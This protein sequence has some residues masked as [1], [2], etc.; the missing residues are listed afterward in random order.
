MSVPRPVTQTYNI[1]RSWA[2]QISFN[3]STGWGGLSSSNLQIEFA[4][5]VS[6]IRIGG[7]AIYSPTLPNSSE[8]AN[9]F[10][11]YKIKRVTTRLDWSINSYNPTANDVAAVVP[12]IF[13]AVDHDDSAD[14]GVTDLLQYPGVITHSFLTNGYKP[15]IIKHT[16]R[17]LRDVAG[18]G[19]TT[20][21]SPM[22][23]NPYLR[24]SGMTTP[25]YGLKI[26]GQSM[27][28]SVNTTV[29]YLLIT[30]YFDLELINP[31]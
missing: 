26:A 31:K 22:S 4:A 27:G 28:A 25:H 7:V 2:Q 29:G 1:R 20:D 17:P 19:I 13:A 11:Q 9:L 30:S 18:T 6:T 8:F 21:Y 14:A 16:P 24:T 23:N 15:L 5:S 12:L 10:D 3:P